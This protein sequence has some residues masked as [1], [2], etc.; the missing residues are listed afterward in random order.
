MPVKKQHLYGLDLVRFG[1]AFIVLLFH[2]STFSSIA[3]SHV[4]T[5]DE[6]PFDWLGWVGTSGWV[7]VEVFFVIS[8]FVI[9]A[10]ARNATALTFLI[11]RA[12][13][14]FPALWVCSIIALGVT[15]AWGMAPAEAL[16]AFLRSIILSPQ[17]P[18]IDGVVWTLVLEAVFYVYIAGLILIGARV[19][20]N[21]LDLGG[22]LLGSVSVLFITAYI[23]ADAI[24]LGITETL[25][26]FPF[27]VALLWHGVFFALGM[28][29][30]KAA[31]D[32]LSGLEYGFA[33]VFTVFC[34]FEIAN[35][36]LAG[37]G[38]FA[39][40]T[41]RIT[42]AIGIWL[43]AMA[44][45]LFSVF[46]SHLVAKAIGAEWVKKAGLMTYPLYLN[47]F[48]FGMCLTPWLAG[49][50]QNEVLLLIAVMSIILASAWA[51]MTGP[52][53][54]LQKLSRKWFLNQ[55]QS[56]AIPM[57]GKKTAERTA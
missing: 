23:V 6:R 13:R 16:G 18:Y 50:I 43:A 26:R 34:L 44:V 56:V 30:Y 28:L 45:M 5:P 2:L 4:T 35:N 47:H 46:R 37:A 41:Y 27:K 54:W 49:Y 3:P 15:L 12:I 57:P 53:I 29:I 25:L 8:G 36:V 20:R 9:A 39:S 10:S 51:I 21:L 52:E 33:A 7:G 48:T 17:G 22:L 19:G 31:R 24:G 1:S 38:G 40:E 42:M 11:K 14:V 55:E 32:R